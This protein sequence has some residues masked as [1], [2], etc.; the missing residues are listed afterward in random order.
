M[1]VNL[2]SDF[3]LGSAAVPVPDCSCIT[4]V[5]KEAVAEANEATCRF[6]L[7]GNNHQPQDS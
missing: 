1:E 5:N 2:S 4:P 6:T 3:P 7:L